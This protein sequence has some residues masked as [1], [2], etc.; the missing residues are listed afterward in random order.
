MKIFIP[1]QGSVDSSVYRVHCIVNDYDSNLSFK[2][3]DETND[4]C[5]YMRMPYPED[6]IPILGVGPSVP[7]P[8]YIIKRLR[9]TD[10]RIHGDKLF[11]MIV[12]EQNAA[13]DHKRYLADQASGDVTERIEKT[14]R[15]HGKSPIVKVFP[16]D[17]KGV[18]ARDN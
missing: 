5:V 18:V 3:N 10:V 17:K 6:P 14:L 8:D 15:K 9:E 1:G 16:N 2:L 12:K 11:D 7:H 4:Y 13:R